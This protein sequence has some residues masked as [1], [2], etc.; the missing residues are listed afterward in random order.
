MLWVAVPLDFDM[1]SD[2]ELRT[3][4]QDIYL[5]TYLFYL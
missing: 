3:S 1:T 4:R 5:G 2:K